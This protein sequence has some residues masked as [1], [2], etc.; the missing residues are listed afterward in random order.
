M[1]EQPA[2]ETYIHGTKLLNKFQGDQ[3]LEEV[4]AYY[5]EWKKKSL[6]I[7]GRSEPEVT[8]LVAAL[9]EYKNA[10]EPIL[11]ERPNSAQE[12]LVSSIIE[13]FLEYLFCRVDDALGETLPVRK[14]AKG[15]LQLIFNPKSITSLVRAPEVTVRTK[16]HDF[17]LGGSVSLRLQGMTVEND[18]ESTELVVPAVAIECKRYLERNMM[19][20]CAGTADKIKTATPYCMYLVLA[21]YLKMDDATPELTRIDEIFILRKQK[22][23]D[24]LAPDFVPNPIDSALVWEMYQMVLRHLGRIWWDPESALTTGRL[25]NLPA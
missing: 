21:E 5:E 20:E 8:E 10:V 19:D 22:N 9:N 13:E 16:D 2:P 12:V 18:V 4:V 14:P 6:G 25:F 23:S 15:F 7:G 1:S 11:D 3:S 24:R 17:V